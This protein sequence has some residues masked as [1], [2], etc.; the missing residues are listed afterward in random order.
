MDG[1][2][3]EMDGD[4][5]ANVIKRQGDEECLGLVER[6]HEP[7]RTV[8]EFGFHVCTKPHALLSLSAM[9]YL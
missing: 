2:I 9:R 4:I 8:E 3:D 7:W 6:I 5:H 1:D